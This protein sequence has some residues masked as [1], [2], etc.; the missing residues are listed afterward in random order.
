MFGRRA[1]DLAAY[2]RCRHLVRWPPS[3]EQPLDWATTGRIF[4]VVS[5]WPRKPRYYRRGIKAWI[6]FGP[7]LGRQDTWWPWCGVPP[8]GSGVVVEAHWWTAGT[9][10]GGRVLWIDK[11]IYVV[12]PLDVRGALR[13]IRRL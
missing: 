5:F 11:L 13:H 2:E 3:L 1:R 8:K 7:Q 4:G 6:Q 10:S 12:P 9:H